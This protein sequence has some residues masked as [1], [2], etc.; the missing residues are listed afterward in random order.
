MD[1]DHLVRL[2]QR[3]FEHVR[4]RLSRGDD[5]PGREQCW[6]E[7]CA[8]LQHHVDRFVVE[9]DPVL[10]RPNTV[11][12]RGLDPVGCLRVCHHERSRGGGLH[13]EHLQLVVA[14]M[15]VP[16]IVTR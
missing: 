4:A 8:R 2:A 9:E 16:R 15:T 1:L 14:E 6:D 12:D 13:D 5:G 7:P 11:P 3:F 10:D